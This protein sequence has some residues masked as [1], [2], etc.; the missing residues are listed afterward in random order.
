MSWKVA[1]RKRLLKIWQLIISLE[2]R[3]GRAV[4]HITRGPMIDWIL[5]G[6]HA[7]QVH[8]VDLYR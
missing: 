8:R 2:R 5:F 7:G 3:H 6:K 4:E 1:R